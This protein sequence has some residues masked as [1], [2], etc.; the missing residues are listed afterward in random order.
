MYLED[1]RCVTSD[2]NE[3]LLLFVTTLQPHTQLLHRSFIMG[4]QTMKLIYKLDS[5]TVFPFMVLQSILLNKQKVEP[6]ILALDH[7][8]D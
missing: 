4:I 3:E 6:A 5:N 7:L 2:K 8:L 1:F